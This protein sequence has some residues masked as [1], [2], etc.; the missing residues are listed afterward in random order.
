MAA[1]A[2]AGLVARRWGGWPRVL[3]VAALASGAA[4]VTHIVSGVSLRLAL[5]LAAGIVALAVWLV[6]RRASPE[7]RAMVARRTRVGLGVGFVATVAYD[8]A[9]VLLSRWDPSPYNPFEA[10]WAFGVRLAGA[11]VPTGLVYTAGG[12]FH[13]VNGLSFGVA[14]C[15]LFA[16]PG[17]LAGIL[18]GFFLELFQ[19]TLYPGWLD[20]R[21]YREFVQI[22]VL[23]HGVYG[24]AL[25]LGCRYGLSPLEG[26]DVRG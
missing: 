3:G 11:G 10:L 18:W 14:F 22:S 17:V 23:A 6:C 5:V 21:F 8:L 4:L 19:L 2:L 16:R 13:L 20:I 24:L 9:R 25:G 12:A 15:L 7:G 26:R 1:G